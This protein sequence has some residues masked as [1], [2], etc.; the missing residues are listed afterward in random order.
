MYVEIQSASGGC[1][2]Q[3]Q[4]AVAMAAASAAAAQYNQPTSLGLPFLGRCQ[5]F[6][7]GFEQLSPVAWSPIT[8]LLEPGMFFSDPAA[9]AQP[10]AESG[11][12]HAGATEGPAPGKLDYEYVGVD[13]ND[14]RNNTRE[15]VRDVS[16]ERSCTSHLQR[17]RR[18]SLPSLHFIWP[19]TDI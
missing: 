4:R 16:Q 13:E 15:E 3:Q 17:G 8:P 10:A 14:E 9:W 18:L 1:Q 7:Q 11:A 2:V 12:D 5:G 6:G 19:D